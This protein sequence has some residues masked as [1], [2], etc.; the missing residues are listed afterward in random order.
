[1]KC[2]ILISIGELVD[3]ITI[4]QIKSEKIKNPIALKNIKYELFTLKKKYDFLDL[5]DALKSLERKLFETN[6]S[7]WNVCEQRRNLDKEKSFGKNYVELSKLEYKLNDERAKIKKLINKI[8]NS[9]IKEE[10]SYIE[11]QDKDNYI[12]ELKKNNNFKNIR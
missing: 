8:T 6:Y 9:D 12:S 1:M 7:L 4:L 2:E 5:S 11:I 3:K 10:K